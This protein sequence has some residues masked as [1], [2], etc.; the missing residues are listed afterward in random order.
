M[1]KKRNEKPSSEMYLILPNNNAVRGSDEDDDGVNNDYD[2]NNIN[3]D[4]FNCVFCLLSLQ[5]QSISL[6]NT[7]KKM[8][9]YRKS[10]L[11]V[12]YCHENT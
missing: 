4:K 7:F 5:S 11:S 2:N 9:I 10:A 12:H 3:H 8:L 6:H 1:G